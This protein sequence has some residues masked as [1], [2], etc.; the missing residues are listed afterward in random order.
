MPVAV[1]AP[2]DGVLEVLPQLIAEGL[3]DVVGVDPRDRREAA[4]TEADPDPA[5]VVGVVVDLPPALLRRD[6]G[7]LAAVVGE[8]GVVVGAV[9]QADAALG[10]GLPEHGQQFD[11]V[12]AA[13]GERYVPG[14]AEHGAP[15]LVRGQCGGG[16]RGVAQSL[17]GAVLPLGGDPLVEEVLQLGDAPHGFALAVGSAAQDV[18]AGVAGDV[19][20]EQGVDGPE[21][22]LDVA[23]GGGAPGRG[24]LHTDAQALAGGQERRGQE[25]PAAVDDHGLRHH[26]RAARGGLQARVS[27]QEVLVRHGRAR[28]RQRVGPGG[29]QRVRD[30]HLGEQQRRVDGLGARRAQDGGQDGAGGDVQRDGQ[31]RAAGG[32]VGEDGHD[33]QAGGVEHDLLARPQRHR[34]RERSPR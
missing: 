27:V 16:H 9:V 31:L 14:G 28:H 20:A 5:G 6:T 30:G 11:V 2:G 19:L 25:D 8:R 10:D 1:P 13:Q 7:G 3:V 4:V 17:G 18:G 23:L 22:A 34:R 12:V 29:A 21:G 32:A 15:H 26:H 24:G 33:V